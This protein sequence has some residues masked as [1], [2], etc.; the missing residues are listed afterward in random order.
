MF[1]ES[2]DSS[3]T[4]LIY[5]PRL[6]DKALL[7]YLNHLDKPY[8]Y[9]QSPSKTGKTLLLSETRN[10]LEEAQVRCAVVSLLGEEIANQ[11]SEQDWYGALTRKLA[12]EF[13]I[14]DSQRYEHFVQL[15]ERFTRHPRIALNKFIHDVLLQEVS[16][17]VVIFI[18]DLDKLLD[19]SLFN[20][21]ENTLK[22]F[23]N[24]FFRTL[25][26]CYERRATSGDVASRA[27]Q[28]NRLTFVLA[29]TA[30]VLELD[31]EPTCT[32]FDGICKCLKLR[33]FTPKQLH[34]SQA[35]LDWI[36][37]VDISSP[38]LEEVLENTKGHPTLTALLLK[39]VL[40]HPIVS[41]VINQRLVANWKTP[42]SPLSFLLAAQ[43]KLER[44]ENEDMR[45][46]C[47]RIL[48]G[49]SIQFDSSNEIHIHL[50]SLGI[51]TER[52]NLLVVHNPIFRIVLQEISQSWSNP[53]STPDSLSPS[54]PLPNSSLPMPSPTNIPS[55]EGG[56][57]SLS[58]PDFPTRLTPSQPITDEEAS[59]PHP[60]F[61]R[62][63]T[64]ASLI[65]FCLEVLVGF[66]LLVIDVGV[67]G[68]WIL[69]VFMLHVLAELLRF[70]EG[71]F[72][73][74]K[75]VLRSF[76][77]EIKNTFTH[78]IVDICSFWGRQRR[79]G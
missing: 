67:S 11:Q 79:A 73:N 20:Q 16:E 40:A 47:N 25:R 29:G 54:F 49:A 5:V 28:Y 50:S 71:D 10:K 22:D 74:L 42:G 45:D 58:F 33:D 9:I 44:P 48:D 21:D 66:I 51:L 70:S 69:P 32:L 2:Y 3:L 36:H 7:Y 61:S 63:I 75:D 14:Y 17:E 72:T 26:R 23:R 13:Q 15:D 38:Y 55:N 19:P 43:Q 77:L 35:F 27:V 18:D 52:S 6:A 56:D 46:L 8:C 30:P 57:S 4:D 24:Q 53:Q 31:I 37:N 39:Q 76:G 65:I 64:K 60:P 34:R 68:S 59:P 62:T 1:D 41:R 78:I 12:R